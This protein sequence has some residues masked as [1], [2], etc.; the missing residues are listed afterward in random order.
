[1][2]LV[3]AGKPVDMA[4]ENLTPL[5]EKGDIVIDGGNSYF[6]DTDIRIKR[7]PGLHYFGMGISGGEEGAR[8]GPSL[9]PGGPKLAYERIRP[10]MEAASAKVD[11][12]P[13]VT[14]LGEGS[15]G[16]FVKMVHNGIEYGLMELI[17]EAYDILHRGQGLSNQKLHELFSAWNQA[18]LNSY[19]IEITANIFLKKDLDGRYLIDE[20]KDVAGQLGTGMWTSQISME[21]Q[22]PSFTID[23]A[24]NMRDLSVKEEERKAIEEQFHEPVKKIEGDLH[25]KDALYAAFLICYAQGFSLLQTASEKLEYHLDQEAVARIWRGGCIIRAAVL[26]EFREAFKRSP[27]LSNL[28]IDPEV[29]SQIKAREPALR[30][31]VVKGAEAGL[32]LAA[33]MASLSY[34]DSFKCGKLPA[35]MIQAERD[36]FGSHRYELE[37]KKGTYHT[38][39]LE[40]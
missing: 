39:W 24:V 2:L 27:N 1:M 25:V 30:E 40:L 28:L 6:K 23:A 16:H 37:D 20:I 29:A 4:L 32:P 11:N 19:L 8:L 26:E 36:Y 12:E 9:M 38:E 33:F 35:N 10:M 15:A 3:P 7:F 18:E 21:F 17:S 14:Y 34:L 22:S 13:C 5:L 31:L